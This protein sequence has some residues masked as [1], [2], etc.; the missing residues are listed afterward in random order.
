MKGK[1][2]YF[3]GEDC[4]VCSTL[5]PRAKKL[6]EVFDLEFEQ[7]HVMEER[8][9]SSQ[10]LVFVIPTLIVTFEDKV[11]VRAERLIDF[12]AVYTTLERFFTTLGEK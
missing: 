4:G 9:R 12:Q 2:T 7:V 8:E 10:A 11:I 6:A 3:Y 1:L 5:L